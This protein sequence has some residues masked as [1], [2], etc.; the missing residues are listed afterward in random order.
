MTLDHL[1]PDVKA[2][3]RHSDLLAIRKSLVG[4]NRED[5]AAALI[6]AGEPEKQ[7]KMR[8]KQLFHWLYYRGASSFDDMTRK[9]VV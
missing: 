8:G 3:D 9:S 1:I 4:M 7:A 5:I 2:V 6:E